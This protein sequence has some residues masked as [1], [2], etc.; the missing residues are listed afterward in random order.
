MSKGGAKTGSLKAQFN[1][2]T[3][4]HSEN[5]INCKIRGSWMLPFPNCQAP[6]QNYNERID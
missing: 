4:F 1:L 6:K 2:I 5:H 3:F